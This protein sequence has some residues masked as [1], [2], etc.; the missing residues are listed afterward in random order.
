LQANGPKILKNGVTI[1]I[2]NKINSQQKVFKRDKE[3]EFIHI[4]GKLYQDELSG[5]NIFSKYTETYIHKGNFMKLK[6]HIEP[7]TIILGDFNSTISLMERQWKQKRN[8]GT[9]KLIEVMKQVDLTDIY[10][11]FY[12]KKKKKKR[13][14]ILSTSSYLL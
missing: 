14:Y 4:K 1:V 7:H 6:E 13:M 10:I 9:V 2:L 5:S 8:R 11:T 3:G 12:P